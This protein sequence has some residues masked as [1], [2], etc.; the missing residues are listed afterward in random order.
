MIRARQH[1]MWDDLRRIMEEEKWGHTRRRMECAKASNVVW[2]FRDLFGYRV[3]TDQRNDGC[4]KPRDG[5]R[6][7][8]S[9]FSQSS[10][11]GGRR[12]ER[13]PLAARFETHGLLWF[14]K[15]AA[16]PLFKRSCRAGRGCP[17]LRPMAIAGPFSSS[18]QSGGIGG[19]HLEALA[20]V[21]GAVVGEPHLELLPLASGPEGG[22]G[23]LGLGR[24]L[25]ERKVV[26]VKPIRGRIALRDPFGRFTFRAR[27]RPRH[28]RLKFPLA[29]TYILPN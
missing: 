28:S 6:G 2:V 4:D 5:V 24:G 18:P 19:E 7:S 15:Q 26:P 11:P 21:A 1:R 14:R 23:L 22:G 17:T 8:M 20:E 13:H 29:I 27:F 3:G 16:S 12:F 9:P 10:G 25:F